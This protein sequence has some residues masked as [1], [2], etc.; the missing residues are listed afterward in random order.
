VSSQQT[1][2]V[3]KKNLLE[4]LSKFGK[5]HTI[6]KGGEELKRIMTTDI[7]DNE[8]MVVFL[9]CLSE[10]NEHMNLNQMKEQIK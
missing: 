3:F 7:T 6:V 9:T 2:F 5:Q 4:V 10:I 1:T 8:K